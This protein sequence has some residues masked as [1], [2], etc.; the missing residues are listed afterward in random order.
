M[1]SV[2]LPPDNSHYTKW[3]LYQRRL[4]GLASK[5]KIPINGQRIHYT[6]EDGNMTQRFNFKVGEAIHRDWF[7]E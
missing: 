7:R 1:F 5:V 2:P 6:L 3:L 4:C